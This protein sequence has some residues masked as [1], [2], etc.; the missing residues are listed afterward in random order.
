MSWSRRRLSLRLGDYRRVLL[1]AFEQLEHPVALVTITQLPEYDNRTA[2]VRW[3]KLDRRVKSKMRREGLRV[4][5]LAR[6]AQRQRRGADH[7]HIPCE[8]APGDR[9]AIERYVELLRESGADFGFG[10]VDNPYFKRHP[11]LNGRPN[12][13][14][15]KRDLIFRDPVIAARYL[16]GYLVESDQL[17]AM[18][19]SR[20]YSF[21]ALWVAPQ[22]TQASGVTC[23]RLRRV[24][25]AY[26]VR[27]A[28]DQGS[29]PTRPV[30]WGDLRERVA[31][32]G[33]L[34]PRVLAATG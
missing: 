33:L 34:R 9:R 23:R 14:L 2:A 6:I 31:V 8:A 29:S 30:W 16:C 5:P 27:K 7:L 15:P 11:K 4:R 25:H 24:R 18:V 17:A 19:S 12:R 21:R 22:L 10:L 20:D 1:A 32:L 26:F 3:S 13:A 28:L